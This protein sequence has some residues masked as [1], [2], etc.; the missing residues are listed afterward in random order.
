M[1]S[2]TAEVVKRERGS[3]ELPP[4]GRARPRH[5]R[6]GDPQLRH[7]DR[8]WA[9]T[10]HAFQ[11]RT[12]DTVIAAMEANHPNLTNQKTLYVEISRARDR[13]ELVTDDAKV[14]QRAARGHDR[15]THRGPR[16]DRA[17]EGARGRTENDPRS[18]PGGLRARVQGADAGDGEDPV[19]ARDR[20]VETRFQSPPTKIIRN[21][22]RKMMPAIDP[23]RLFRSRSRAVAESRRGALFLPLRV[24][25]R[26]GRRTPSPGDLHF[27]QRGACARQA[28][29]P[30]P[31]RSVDGPEERPL[32]RSGD[33]QPSAAGATL[34]R[35]P[36]ICLNS[37]RSR[38]GRLRYGSACRRSGQRQRHTPEREY[39]CHRNPPT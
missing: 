23:A 26:H 16:G 3:R 36:G 33:Q 13:A 19:V 9:S 8:A 34:A 28:P 35:A 24:G 4:R 37:P 6:T 18:R 25:F 12:V 2:Q 27:D 22:K 29:E 7:I 17:G 32:R 39:A 20:D 1:N 21:D 38:T 14:L 5:D 10:V 31:A 30:H 11:G 15:R